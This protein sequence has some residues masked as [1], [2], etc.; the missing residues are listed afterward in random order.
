MRKLIVGDIHE[1]VTHPGYRAFVM[2]VAERYQT[3]DVLFIGDIV[4]WHAI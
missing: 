4:D 3:D 1:P 2:D